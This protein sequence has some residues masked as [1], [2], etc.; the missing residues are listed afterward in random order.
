MGAVRGAARRAQCKIDEEGNA[1]KVV[2]CSCAVVKDFGEDSNALQ[3]LLEY[4]KT[5]GSADE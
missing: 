3:T 5:R 2:P 4:L 1:R